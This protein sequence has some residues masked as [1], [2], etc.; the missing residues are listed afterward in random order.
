MPPL[1]I[2]SQFLLYLPYVQE[3]YLFEKVKFLWVHVYPSGD[4]AANVVG[5]VVASPPIALFPVSHTAKNTPFPYLTLFQFI[6]VESSRFGILDVCH[7]SVTGSPMQYIAW[8]VFF[9]TAT[10]LPLP[11]V[12]LHQSYAPPGVGSL[13][14]VTVQVIPSL[15]VAIALSLPESAT[16]FP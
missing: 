11:K 8:P 12:K 4:D 6:C 13:S 16:H 1:A 5:P 2:T 3:L 10:N 14:S 9:D 7:V 15:D